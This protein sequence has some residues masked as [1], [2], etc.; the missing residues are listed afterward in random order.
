[1][2]NILIGCDQTYYDT[3]ARTLLRS[4]Q[5]YAPWVSL[6]CHIVNPGNTLTRLDHVSY[7]TE[8]RD[9]SDPNVFNGYLQAVRFLKAY[10]LFPNNEPVIIVDAD[11]ICTRSFSQEQY[12]QVHL[13]HPVV[14]YKEKTTRWLAGFISMGSNTFRKDFYDLLMSKPIEEWSGFWDQTCLKQLDNKYNFTRCP[15]EWMSIG[16]LRNSHFLTLKG[17]QKE[18]DKYLDQ[19]IKI[20]KSIC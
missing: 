14:L 18:T 12:D 19:Y 9:L 16:K 1:M 3:W 13:D 11:S 2:Y 20:K 17:E 8:E 4:I 10:E 6:H 5:H 15:S 7:T